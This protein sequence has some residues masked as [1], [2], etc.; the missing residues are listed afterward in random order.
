MALRASSGLPSRAAARSFSRPSVILVM[1]EWTTRT[2]FPDSSRRLTTSAMLRQLAS[3]ETLVPPNLTT[4]QLTDIRRNL[5]AESAT[6]HCLSGTSLERTP[7]GVSVLVVFERIFQVFFEL[8]VRQH[9][10]EAAPGS[11]ATFGSARLRS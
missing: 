6:S 10:L 2:R 4:T 1:A 3:E 9:F 7:Q 8:T 11:L 5:V